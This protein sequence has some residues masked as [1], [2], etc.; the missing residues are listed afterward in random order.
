MA[1][2]HVVARGGQV[3]TGRGS[4]QFAAQEAWT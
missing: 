3:D 4:F 1:Y 2:M